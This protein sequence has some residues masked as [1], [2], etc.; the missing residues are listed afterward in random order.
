LIVRKCWLTR[1]LIVDRRALTSA[2]IVDKRAL[3]GVPVF[4]KHDLARVVIV[5]K[6][7][8]ISSWSSVKPLSK[9]GTK[10]L[11][12]MRRCCGSVNVSMSYSSC[13]AGRMGLR[14]GRREGDVRPAGD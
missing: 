11:R 9:A 10:L 4:E 7:A 1:V 8:L 13:A 12:P 6:S 14:C 2:L 3:T 5:E